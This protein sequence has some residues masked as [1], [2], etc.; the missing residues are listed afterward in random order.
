MEHP[1]SPYGGTKLACEF[2]IGTWAHLYGI[3]A[4]SLRY[5]TI[6]G[7]RQRPEMAIHRFVRRMLNGEAIPVFGDGSS[8]RDYT[9]VL[10][11]VAGTVASLDRIERMTQGNRI[12][13]IG[14]SRTI[15]LR[16]L[17]ELLGRV[18]G[19]E[20]KI[21]QMPDQPGDVP[22]TWADISRASEELGYEPRT[23]LEEGLS[24]FLT[25]YRDE[26]EST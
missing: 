10:D 11:A 25:W 8:R 21:E 26:V 12:Y 14:G 20:P 7:P 16:D 22:A 23:P 9:F 5:F 24:H 15:Q 4:A 1:Y 17:V 13:N 18:L 6:Y 2:L 19:I 3:R